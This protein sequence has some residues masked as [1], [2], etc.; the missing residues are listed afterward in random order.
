MPAPAAR[1]D[2]F[3][4]PVTTASPEA[5]EAVDRFAAEVLGHGKE[6]AAVLAGVEADPGCALA[7]AYAGALYLFL[8]TAEGRTRAAPFVAAAGTLAPKATERERLVVSA[9]DAWWRGEP[10]LALARHAEVARRWPRDLLNAKLAQIHQLNRGDRAG[11]CDL[12]LHV[13]AANR[14][15]GRA[16]GLAAFGL[17]QAGRARAA[18]AHGRRAVELRPDDGWAHHAVA[19]VLAQAGRVEEGLDWMHAHAGHWDRCSSFLYT[20]NWWHTA[21]F[22]L[23]RGEPLRALSLFDV[24]VW[25]V[26]K[27]YVQDQINA[28]AL[29][30][31]LEL[32]GVGV[33]TERWADVARHVRPRVRDQANGF[34]D[35]HFAYA[36]ARAGD[37]D[38][39]AELL[40][41]Q[42]RHAAAT[43]DP[44][45]REVVPAATRGLAAHAAGDH[46]AA[47]RLLD[48]VAPRLRDLGG[49]TVQHQWFD[50]LRADSLARLRS[51][52]APVSEVA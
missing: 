46:A 17:D 42:A 44:C 43:R 9:V 7:Q 39:L 48:R 50:R 5:V 21:L 13:L 45:W 28:V 38:G 6:A 30:S 3:G 8:Q 37:A 31:R 10:A 34:I 14:G 11:M 29:L 51:T 23:D 36:L 15:D 35:L 1:P 32:R 4:L 26:R 18:E 20:H 12:A 24:R 33:G 25:G 40:E 49:S 52:A 19:H 2:C 27:T 47:V 22:H 41:S 16:W